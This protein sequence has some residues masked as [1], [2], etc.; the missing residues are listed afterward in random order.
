MSLKW[1]RGV[2]GL[3]GGREGGREEGREAF[4]QGNWDIADVRDVCWMVVVE[5]E[6]GIF[7]P[8]ACGWL[9]GKNILKT[10][11]LTN[12]KS[13]SEMLL[14]SIQEMLDQNNKSVVFIHNLSKFDYLF[15]SKLLFSNFNVKP[16]YKDG[17]I[18]HISIQFTSASM[19]K[20]L[21][22]LFFRFIFSFRINHLNII[23]K[24][25][26]LCFMNIV[27]I[28]ILGV[29]AGV[30]IFFIFLFFILYC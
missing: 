9:N 20:T 2:I 28:G 17:N 25:L 26:T 22:F 27:Y 3:E 23:N 6:D 21:F 1:S 10:Y 19:M 13:N 12:F 14:T 24:G 11:Y 15:L 18:T 5:D 8:Y 30:A 29:F 4:C 16:L 7:I